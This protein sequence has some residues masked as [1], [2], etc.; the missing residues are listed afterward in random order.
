MTG[1]MSRR[2]LLAGTGV[3]SAALVAAAGAGLDDAGAS[4]QP[5]GSSAIPFDGT[6]QAGI[7]TPEQSR[8]VFATFDVTAGDEAELAALLDEWT[9]RRGPA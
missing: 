3:A 6:H 7:T 1:R 8:M 9:Q 4:T 2:R 5:S